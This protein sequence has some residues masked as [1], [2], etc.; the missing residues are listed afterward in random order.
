MTEVDKA[1]ADALESGLVPG[2]ATSNDQDVDVPPPP[3]HIPSAHFYRFVLKVGAK[4]GVSLDV[5]NPYHEDTR[6][7]KETRFVWIPPASDGWVRN[8]WRDWMDEQKGNT[9][10]AGIVKRRKVGAYWWG[11]RQ[12][13]PVAEKE[14]AWREEDGLIGLNLHGGAYAVGS[15]QEEDITAS[16]CFLHVSTTLALTDCDRRHPSTLDP[17]PADVVRPVDRVPSDRLR[18]LPSSIPRRPGRLPSPRLGPRRAPVQS[19]RL[20]RLGWGPFGVGSVEVLDG[21]ER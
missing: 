12:K 18:T 14:E 6:H 16:A 1:A 3:R 10:T 5:R 11:R 15:A 13:A 19:H 2:A 4:L 17:A 7:R 20:R 8:E 9:S 21:L